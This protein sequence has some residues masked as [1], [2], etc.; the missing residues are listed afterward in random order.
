MGK[1]PGPANRRRSIWRVP[2]CSRGDPTWK[3]CHPAGSGSHIRPHA[4]GSGSSD[5]RQHGRGRQQRT[6]RTGVSAPTWKPQH[7]CDRHLCRVT[8]KLRAPS[9]LTSSSPT[10]HSPRV[11]RAGQ[12]WQHLSPRGSTIP[13]R[14]NSLRT[15]QNKQDEPKEAHSTAAARQLGQEHQVPLCFQCP[16]PTVPPPPALVHPIACTEPPAGPAPGR[17]GRSPR[18][19]RPTARRRNT[20]NSRPALHAWFARQKRGPAQRAMACPI[21]RRGR[22]FL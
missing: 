10:N 19:G 15:L 18:R 14:G 13:S 4:F 7:V 6:G 3:P 1:R 17:S 20:A 21:G 16:R 9:E 11:P 22:V 12:K 2:R 5:T 8:S